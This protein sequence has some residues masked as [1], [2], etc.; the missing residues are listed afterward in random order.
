MIGQIYTVQSEITMSTALYQMCTV[1]MWL[2]DVIIGPEIRR[3]Q[4]DS[5]GT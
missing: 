4:S 1:E 3:V 5:D 2:K